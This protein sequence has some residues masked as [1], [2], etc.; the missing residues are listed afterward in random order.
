VK[1]FLYTIIGVAL[2]VP[3]LARADQAP[4]PLPKPPA[5]APAPSPESRGPVVPLKLTVLV[6]KYQND[7]KVSSLPYSLS[8]NS[9]GVRMSMRMGAQVPYATSTASEGKPVPGYNYRD[10]GISIDAFAIIHEPG[11]YRVDLTVDDTSI[12]TNNQVQ[13]A[14]SITGVPVFRNFRAGNSV[15]LR[16]GQ[17]TQMISAADP[18]SGETMRVDVTLAVAK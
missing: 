3:A 15:L 7:K 4:N 11:M 9:N 5:P 17:T 13:G 1:Q 2:V 12:T 6:S 10:V 8:L 16:D 14:P 18:I